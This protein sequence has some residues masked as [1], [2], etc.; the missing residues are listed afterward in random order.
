[1]AD[2]DAELD[3]TDLEQMPTRARDVVS[4]FARGDLGLRLAAEEFAPSVVDDRDV[5]QAGVGEA[6]RPEDRRHA[7]GLGPVGDGRQDARLLGRA[8]RQ[9]V[10]LDAAQA[11]QIRLREADDRCTTGRRLGLEAAHLGEALVERGRDPR[12]RQRDSHG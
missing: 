8:E 9:N 11:G 5:L 6:L 2:R 7:V 3:A 4:V 1:V 10:D 12:R